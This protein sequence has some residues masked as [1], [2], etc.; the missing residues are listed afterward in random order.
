[1]VAGF[2]EELA[3][4]G[5]HKLLEHFSYIGGVLGELA[6]ERTGDGEGAAEAAGVL[7]AEA[8]KKLGSGAVASIGDGAAEAFIG[9]IIEIVMIRIK[10]AE[11]AESAGLVQLE[12]EDGPYHAACALRWHLW[13]QLMPEGMRHWRV[14]WL[15][16]CRL[17]AFKTGEISDEGEAVLD[18]LTTYVVVAAEELG[19][20][21]AGFGG[22]GG[23]LD[24]F[25]V[26]GVGLAAAPGVRE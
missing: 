1:M 2:G 16:G 5:S 7:V 25:V 23:E 13:I 11:P 9:Y 12:I 20:H 8:G 24:A 14:G 10:D 3:A 21:V 19:G 6:Q 4:A 26:A 18:K 22:D 17:E 15:F